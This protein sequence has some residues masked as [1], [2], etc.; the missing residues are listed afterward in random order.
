MPTTTALPAY[1]SLHEAAARYGVS[2]TV[3]RRAV[4]DGAVRAV[5]L[6]DGKIAV[7]DEDIAVIKTQQYPA[8]AL[9]TFISLREAA[10]RYQLGET[11]LRRAVKNGI[12]RAVRLTEGKIAVADEDAAVVAA[13]TKAVAEGDELVSISE[14]S[15][16]LHIPPGTVSR[17][18]SYGWLPQVAGGERGAK[19]VSWNRA[20]ILA[21]LRNRQGK[22]GRRLIP[23]KKEINIAV[24]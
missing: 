18:V 8:A 11:V 1:I 10:V 3:L 15:R 14:A 20:Q 19:L 12:I 9:P 7:A 16:R 2:E 5:Q 24:S 23:K 21:S 13:Q 4:S 17:W 6:A 22:R